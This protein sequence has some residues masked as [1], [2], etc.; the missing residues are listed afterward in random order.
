MWAHRSERFPR[1]RPA[2]AETIRVKSSDASFGLISRLT[3]AIQGFVASQV[4]TATD[5]GRR[6]IELPMVQRRILVDDL[7]FG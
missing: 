6:A 1:C 2:D 3:N 7:H 4:D 5:H